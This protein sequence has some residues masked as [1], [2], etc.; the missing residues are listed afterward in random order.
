MSD[1]VLLTIAIVFVLV[2]FL[3]TVVTASA[4][5]TVRRITN[6]IAADAQLASMPLAH[7]ETVRQIQDAV[8]QFAKAGLVTKLKGARGRKRATTGR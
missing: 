5:S 2:A 7:R 3:L 4:S 6:L 1:V 8:S